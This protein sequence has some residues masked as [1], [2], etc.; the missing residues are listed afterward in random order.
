MRYAAA[1]EHICVYRDEYLTGTME[2]FEQIEQAIR[3][4]EHITVDFSNCISINAAAAVMTFAKITRYQLIADATKMELGHQALKIRPP[5][6]KNIRAFFRKT[7]FHD[8]IRPGGQAKLARLWEDVDNP[9]KTSNSVEPDIRALIRHLKSRLGKVPG[10]LMS[11]LSEGYLNINHH[12][13][14]A[15]LI[16]ELF[17][18]WWQYTTSLRPNGTFSVV[19]YDSGI[20]IPQSLEQKV[21]R[22]IGW[23]TDNSVIEYAMEK[24]N[25]R[26]PD[27]FG[28]GNGFSNIKQP[29]DINKKA[30]HLFIASGKGSVTY[31]DQKIIKS[32]FHPNYKFGGTLIEWCFDGEMA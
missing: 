8:A 1:P 31:K 23:C 14:E 13:Y 20:G 2:F 9:F 26:Y 11:A 15:N 32:D 10:K 28:R 19:L 12:A 18:R 7:G 22:D 30:K 17:G 29:V 25:T 27:N 21:L 4:R 3:V 16:D 5:K 24:G 6:D